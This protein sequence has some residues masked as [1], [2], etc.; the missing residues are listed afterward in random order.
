MLAAARHPNP[1]G[2]AADFAILDEAAFDIRFDVDV[3][4]LAAVR[5]GHHMLIRHGDMLLASLPE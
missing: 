3:H 4:G 5:A 1:P 2:I